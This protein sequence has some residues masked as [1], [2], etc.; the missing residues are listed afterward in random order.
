MENPKCMFPSLST[1]AWIWTAGASA[2]WSRIM[3]LFSTPRRQIQSESEAPRRI[4]RKKAASSRQWAEVAVMDVRGTCFF[5][6]IMNEKNKED[7]AMTYN[8]YFHLNTSRGAELSWTISAFLT[9]HSGISYQDGRAATVER[10]TK[11]FL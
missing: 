5:S 8:Y 2:Y 3:N 9:L 4:P 6:L 10:N 11:E 1:S 7:V